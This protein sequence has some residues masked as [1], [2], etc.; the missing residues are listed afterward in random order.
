MEI[1]D[2]QVH[3]NMVGLEEGLA[4]MDAVGVDAVIIDEYVSPNPR[5][6]PQIGHFVADTVFRYETPLSEIAVRRFP[7]RFAYVARVSPDDPELEDL[8]GRVRDQRGRLALRLIPHLP[9]RP[10]SPAAVAPS[11]SASAVL[12]ERIRRGDFERYFRSAA[13]AGVPVFLQLSGNDL[14][15][16]IALFA[17]I[18]RRHPALALIV[19]HMGVALPA[20]PGSDGE[21]GRAGLRLLDELASLENVSFK[22]CHM[23]RLSREPYPYPD[24][25]AELRRLVELFGAHRIMW[26]S[27]WTIDLGWNSWSEA[28]LSVRE[29][30]DLTPEDRALILGGTARAVLGWP[31]PSA[32]SRP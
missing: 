2:S 30:A 24:I 17:S 8:I 6:E 28:L 9:V 20:R 15:G 26:A 14:P 27:D 12:L 11:G 4:A 5:Q 25:A 3:L 23:I 7:E 32:S 16:D 21:P 10:G 1:V 19:D 31:A 29:D 22:W 13:D 18:A